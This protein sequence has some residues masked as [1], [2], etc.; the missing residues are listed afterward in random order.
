MTDS[1]GGI[2][3]SYNQVLNLLSQTCSECGYGLNFCTNSTVV[4]CVI[5]NCVEMVALRYDEEYAFIVPKHHRVLFIITENPYTLNLFYHLVLLYRN[6]TRP[7]QKF[8]H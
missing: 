4:L 8:H 5:G 7:I 1:L 3:R 2:C 6:V